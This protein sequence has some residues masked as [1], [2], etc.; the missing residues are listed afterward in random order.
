MKRML[1]QERVVKLCITKP[2]N[3]LV[4]QRL[5]ILKEHLKISNLTTVIK[6]GAGSSL[7]SF[8]RI[9]IKFS[10]TGSEEKT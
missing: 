1:L 5:V 4:F 8:N 6:K 7:Y 3:D 9:F 10:N 2:K